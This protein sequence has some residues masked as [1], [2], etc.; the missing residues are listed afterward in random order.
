MCGFMSPVDMLVNGCIPVS[1]W[2]HLFSEK[3]NQYILNPKSK[4]PYFEKAR[5]GT[6]LSKASDNFSFLIF[7][8]KE[9]SI[10]LK[11][12]IKVSLFKK[13]PGKGHIYP[14]LVIISA[15]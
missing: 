15:F 5:Q 14:R 3:K 12:K 8:R 9:E 13:K 7:F 6:Y 4:C 11:S 10:Y 1:L 2:L